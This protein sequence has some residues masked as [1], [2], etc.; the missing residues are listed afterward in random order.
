MARPVYM[1]NAVR[2][3]EAQRYLMDHQS[4]KEVVGLNK[5]HIIGLFHSSVG[6]LD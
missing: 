1:H 2:F 6:E 3:Y 5:L 4:S